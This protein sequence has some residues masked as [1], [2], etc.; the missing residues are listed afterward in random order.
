L[1]DDAIDETEE[2]DLTGLME[3]TAEER[4]EMK[5]VQYRVFITLTEYL[6]EETIK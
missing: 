4:D 3:L 5:D 2:K 1:L 6:S